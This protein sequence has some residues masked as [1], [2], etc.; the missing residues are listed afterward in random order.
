[1]IRFK[2]KELIA[3]K[4]FSGGKRVTVKEISELT[5]IGRGTLS[6]MI[7]QKGANTTLDNIDRLC[8]FFNCEIQDVVVYIDK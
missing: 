6:K 3:D 4:E 8:K 7:N 5:G 1:M 2:L